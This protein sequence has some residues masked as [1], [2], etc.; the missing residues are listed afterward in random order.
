MADWK[1]ADYTDEITDEVENAWNGL[2][3]KSKKNT[4]KG[5]WAAKAV[6]AAVDVSKEEHRRSKTRARPK[7]M[8][9]EVAPGRAK[10]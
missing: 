8:A 1:E 6:E 9:Q 7:K 10:R 3:R 5:E 2:K 4:D